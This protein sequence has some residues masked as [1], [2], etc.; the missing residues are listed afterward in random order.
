MP[1]KGA[2]WQKSRTLSLGGFTQAAPRRG[3]EG[4]IVRAKVEEE[5]FAGKRLDPGRVWC[6]S[7]QKTAWGEQEGGKGKEE[8]GCRG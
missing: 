5:D 6:I 4:L 2:S 8:G 7:A 1:W 3:G